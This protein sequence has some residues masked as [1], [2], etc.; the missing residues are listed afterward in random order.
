M[1]SP[2]SAFTHSMFLLTAHWA[3]MDVKNVDELPT[4][5]FQVIDPDIG[6]PRTLYIH[7]ALD[8]GYTGAL[9]KDT[10]HDQRKQMIDD[11]SLFGWYCKLGVPP[12]VA[13]AA[14]ERIPYWHVTPHFIPAMGALQAQDQMVPYKMQFGPL[15]KLMTY[16]SMKQRT[17]EVRSNVLGKV[18]IGDE[19]LPWFL[20]YNE[21]VRK[22]VSSDNIGWLAVSDR[23]AFSDSL[24]VEFLRRWPYFSRAGMED[25]KPKFEVLGKEEYNATFPGTRIIV[26]LDGWK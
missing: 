22:V 1:Y 8:P 24:D 15:F 12:E 18:T 21:A 4:W 7:V 20:T 9:T 25:L 11:R 13:Q 19:V 10:I 6:V 3:G 16:R 14:A 26:D 17:V 2:V 23:K 5:A